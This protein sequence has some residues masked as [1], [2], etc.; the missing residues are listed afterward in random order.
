VT[1]QFNYYAAR[2]AKFEAGSS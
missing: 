1:C 2:N